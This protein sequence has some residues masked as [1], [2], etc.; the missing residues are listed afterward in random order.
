[1]CNTYLSVLYCP[2][3]YN[4]VPYLYSFP[5]IQDKNMYCTV[6]RP[7]GLRPKMATSVWR[8]FNEIRRQIFF[9]RHEYVRRFLESF[10]RRGLLLK[11]TAPTISTLT[12]MSSSVPTQPHMGI[13]SKKQDPGSGPSDPLLDAAHV[14]LLQ[15]YRNLKLE[16]DQIHKALETAFTPGHDALMAEYEREEA[17]VKIVDADL[18]VALAKEESSRMESSV[19]K[20]SLENEENARTAMQVAMNTQAKE[21][22]LLKRR[23]KALREKGKS[24]MQQTAELKAEAKDSSRKNLGLQRVVAKQKEMIKELNAKLRKS[25]AAE[26]KIGSRFEKLTKVYEASRSACDT[27][28]KRLKE[29]RVTARSAQ[30]DIRQHLKLASQ[31]V[32]ALEKKERATARAQNSISFRRD[33]DRPTSREEDPRPYTLPPHSTLMDGNRGVLM[34]PA[35]LARKTRLLTP[36]SS[37]SDTGT[38]YLPLPYSDGERSI[39]WADSAEPARAAEG[40][41]EGASSGWRALGPIRGGSPESEPP[42]ARAS[43][44]RREVREALPNASSSGQEKGH[45]RNA[46]NVSEPQGPARAGRSAKRQR[47]VKNSAPAMSTTETREGSSRRPEEADTSGAAV[48]RTAGGRTLRIRRPV[49]YDYNEIGRDIA[50]TSADF[51]VDWTQL[52]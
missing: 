11:F 23:V 50:I 8:E 32:Q 15:K 3:L 20:A 33:K 49:S 25:E 27:L 46:Q 38:E 45:K 24:A 47:V 35:P 9:R 30:R 34:S 19:L 51:E 7:S 16:L 28:E 52:E 4:I 44:K 37:E 2:A 48:R 12:D 42:L 18:K 39:D 5:K 6:P 14:P 26:K 40:A 36:I 21:V 10:A 17:R 1:M 29:E 13:D 22:D 41:T 31:R 43:W